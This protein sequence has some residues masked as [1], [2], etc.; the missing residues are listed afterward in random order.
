M[1]QQTIPTRERSF[2]VYLSLDAA[3]ATN[4]VLNVTKCTNQQ[5]SHSL[6]F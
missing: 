1:N 2:P 3:A 6:A 4:K 5:L